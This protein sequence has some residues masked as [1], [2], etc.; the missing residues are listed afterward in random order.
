MYAIRS[1]YVFFSGER[2]QALGRTPGAFGFGGSPGRGQGAGVEIP[3]GLARLERGGL[4]GQGGGDLR[5][6]ASYNFV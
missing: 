5:V 1:Y 3:E 6:L 4:P 2:L